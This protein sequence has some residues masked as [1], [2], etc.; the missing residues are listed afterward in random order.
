MKPVKTELDYAREAWQQAVAGSYPAELIAIAYRDL[1][2][3]ERKAA[4]SRKSR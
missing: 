1:R 2:A 4:K 3:A